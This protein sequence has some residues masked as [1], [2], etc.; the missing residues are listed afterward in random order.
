MVFGFEMKLWLRDYWKLGGW[1]FFWGVVYWGGGG[2]MS[3]FSASGWGT[4][5]HPPSRENSEQC[6]G[7]IKRWLHCLTSEPKGRFLV[8]IILMF[9]SAW[10]LVMAQIHFSLINKIKIGRPE[11]LL[12]PHPSTYDNILFSFQISDENSPFSIG[13]TLENLS[14]Q[15]RLLL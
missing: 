10:C 4:S 11:H 6:N 12:T 3:K 2:R 1:S 7:I 15:V 5:L 8:N 14:A 9:G 13:I